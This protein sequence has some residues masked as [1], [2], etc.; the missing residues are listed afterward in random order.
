MTSLSSSSQ[1]KI[2]EEEK[3]AWVQAPTFATTLKLLLLS[4]SC[5]HHIEAPL[6]GAFLKLRTLEAPMDFHTLEALNYSS[7][8]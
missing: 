5:C 7:S 2:K 6:A 1:E 8:L 3:G 4:W